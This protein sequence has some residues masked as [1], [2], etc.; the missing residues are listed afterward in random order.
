MNAWITHVTI[1]L[2]VFFLDIN[3]CSISPCHVNASCTDNEGS[4]NCHCKNGFFGDG[5]NC[6][7]MASFYS[8]GALNDQ[9]FN[10]NV[11]CVFF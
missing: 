8:F 9:M 6:T 1:K 4:F 7:S 2:H 5:F 3:E 11:F 10:L